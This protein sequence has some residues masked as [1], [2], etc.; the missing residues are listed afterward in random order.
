MGN[1]GQGKDV[2]LVA[3][4]S[5]H[6]CSVL[7]GRGKFVLLIAMDAALVGPALAMLWKPL[8]R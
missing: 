2:F 4:T 6:E 3:T 7:E 1:L 8:L 5:A